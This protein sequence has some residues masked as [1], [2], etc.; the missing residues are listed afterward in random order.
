M[1]SYYSSY[2]SSVLQKQSY[3]G[4]NEARGFEQHCFFLVS[5]QQNLLKLIKRKAN[6]MKFLPLVHV[7]QNKTAITYKKLSLLKHILRKGQAMT[8]G[9]Q[10]DCFLLKAWE[11]LHQCWSHN[12]PKPCVHD[13][14]VLSWIQRHFYQLCESYLSKEFFSAKKSFIIRDPFF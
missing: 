12:T 7:L 3:K 11:Q 10:V 4:E 5:L 1:L 9:C 8:L 13:L 14:R 2:L 6:K